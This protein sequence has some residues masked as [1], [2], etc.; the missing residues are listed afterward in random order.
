[1]LLVLQGKMK[2]CLCQHIFT[3]QQSLRHIKNGKKGILTF[4]WLSKS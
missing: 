2:R 4:L 3:A 1:M